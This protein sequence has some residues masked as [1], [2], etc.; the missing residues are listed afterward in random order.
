MQ[1][2]SQAFDPDDVAMMGR[3]CDEALSEA[4]RR[5][6]LPLIVDQ[7]DLRSLV[8][9]RIMAAVVVGQRDPERLKAIALDALDAKSGFAIAEP[10]HPAHACSM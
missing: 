8:A 9:A 2:P 3:I 10:D 1:L 4:Q 7:S 6:S 5:L